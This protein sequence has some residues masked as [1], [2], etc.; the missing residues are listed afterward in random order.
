MP[1]LEARGRPEAPQQPGQVRGDGG[2][3]QRVEEL[4]E[5]GQRRALRPLE[6]HARDDHLSCR[7]LQPDRPARA[8]PHRRLLPLEVSEHRSRA[9]AWRPVEDLG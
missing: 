7:L 6:S 5:G 2:L 8:L 3:T 4:K 9:A 1:C